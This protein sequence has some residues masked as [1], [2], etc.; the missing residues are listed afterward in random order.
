MR[1]F[2]VDVRKE[3]TEYGFMPTMQLYLL[4]KSEIKRP[5]VII[6]PGG[7]YT[8]VCIEEDADQV[9]MQYNAAGFHAAVLNY[10][11]VPHCFPEPQKD[12]MYAIRL[13]RENAEN[14]GIQEDA[15]AICG[16]SAGAHLC[17]SVSTLWQKASENA[18]VFKPNGVILFYPILTTR[19]AHCRDFLKGHAGGDEKL[20][21]WAACDEQV[22]GDTPP[23]FMYGTFEDKLSNVENM[24]YYGEKLKAHGV[25]FEMHVLPKGQHGAPWCEN[26]T[27]GKSVSGR[28][29]HYIGLSIEWLIELFD[30]E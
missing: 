14:W 2:Q 17:A 7:G 19:L 22:T 23:T 11:V 30:R 9:A 1:Y 15:I 13:L 25:P 21:K 12:L 16:F 28:S 10:S 26:K 8:T 3:P 6:A 4:E 29:Y 18:C 20:L 5:V 27:W 24:L